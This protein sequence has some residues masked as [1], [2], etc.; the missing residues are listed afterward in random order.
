MGEMRANFSQ[1]T[2]YVRRGYLRENRDMVKRFVRAYSD[3]VHVIK[4]DRERTLKVFAK[5]MRLDDPE[6]LN[7]TYDYYAPRFSFPPRVDMAGIKDTLDFYAETNP[8]V[9]GR[10]PQEFV[11]HSLLDELEREGFFK[12]LGS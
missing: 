8:E 6:I 11:D 3:A 5:R 7:A 1:S 10:S 9:R 12:S 4:T 2:L